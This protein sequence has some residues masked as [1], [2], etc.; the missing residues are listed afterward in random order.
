MCIRR[1]VLVSSAPHDTHPSACH[2]GYKS[3]TTTRCCW[4]HPERRCPLVLLCLRSFASFPELARVSFV[5]RW[6]VPLARTDGPSSAA[7]R[8]VGARHCGSCC[9]GR[10]KRADYLPDERADE[11][12]GPG[13]RASRLQSQSARQMRSVSDRFAAAEPLEKATLHRRGGLMRLVSGRRG[14]LQRLRQADAGPRQLDQTHAIRA[15]GRALLPLELSVP[16]AHGLRH[17]LPLLDKRGGHARTGREQHQQIQ[18]SAD[19][20]HRVAS[21]ASHASGASA[22]SLAGSRRL[23]FPESAEAAGEG[24]GLAP[25]AASGAPARRS[26]GVLRVQNALVPVKELLVYKDY[27]DRMDE[28][29]CGQVTVKTMND[30]LVAHARAMAKEGVSKEARRASGVF[31]TL[32]ARIKMLVQERGGHAITLEEYFRLVY[33]SAT[34]EQCRN[35]VRRIAAPRA[36][37]TKDLS[38]S[39]AELAEVDRMW[40]L[41]DQ[42]GNGE[43]DEYEFVA[44]MRQLG[45]GARDE[46]VHF[47]QVADQGNRGFVDKEQFKEWFLLGDM[48][49]AKA[50]MSSEPSV[51]RVAHENTRSPGVST[52]RDRGKPARVAEEPSGHP[53]SELS[54]ARDHTHAEGQARRGRRTETSADAQV[55]DTAGV[56]RRELHDAVGLGRSHSHPVPPGGPREPNVEVEISEPARTRSLGTEA[57]PLG[58]AALPPIAA[59][60]RS[61]RVTAGLR[62]VSK[63]FKERLMSGRRS[64]G[65]KF[66]DD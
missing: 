13:S 58:V 64:S 20:E 31:T 1:L 43:L 40:D 16:R 51:E 5:S 12:A 59:R 14:D 29:G 10:P 39:A 22:K 23:S 57:K 3:L 45:V 44:V 52:G 25:A 50:G 55:H 37:L 47:F 8:I 34:K 61:F 66:S 6:S 60:S 4:L 7:E 30:H 65:L 46:A 33:H 35:I 2:H 36:K 49:S 32:L 27:F 54:E 11:R 53:R 63:T 48:T 24:G 15:T 21:L 18:A 62:E 26:G 28:G 56:T 9:S 41:W 38:P 19:A 17:S 42:D